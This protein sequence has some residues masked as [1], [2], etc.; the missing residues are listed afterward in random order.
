MELQSSWDCRV[1]G[2]PDPDPATLCAWPSAVSGRSK[3]GTVNLTERGP[4]CEGA[5]HAGPTAGSQGAGKQQ[6]D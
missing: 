6:T 2:P 5:I 4:P 1:P 3:R